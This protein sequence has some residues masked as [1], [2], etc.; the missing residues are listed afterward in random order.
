MEIL[1]SFIVVFMV[2]YL[3][4][5]FF[6][7]L[8]KNKLSKIKQSSEALLIKKKYNLKL[9]KISDKKLANIIAFSN[10]FIIATTFIVIEFVSNFILKIMV[11]FVVLIVLILSIYILIGKYLKKKEG[12]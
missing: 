4:Y 3:F 6:V 10:A 8:R 7:I 9:N 1:I 2:V 5:L 12:K 11:S